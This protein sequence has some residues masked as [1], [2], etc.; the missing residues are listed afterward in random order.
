MKAR[1]VKGLD[2]EASLADNAE[3]IVLVRLDELHR[4]APAALDPSQE[5]ALHDMRIAA[6]RLR[7]VL[8]VTEPALGSAAKRGIGEARTLQEVLG[9]I[10]DCDVMLATVRA[11]AKRLRAEDAAAVRSALAPTAV[12]VKPEQIAGAPNLANYRGLEALV[13][14][15]RVRRDVLFAAFSEQWAELDR[16]GFRKSLEQAVAERPDTVEHDSA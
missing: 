1:K 2:C 4:L 6:K 9:E 3:R 13:T 12:D 10:H 15:L 7:Y 16:E 14:Y 5:E 8:E 11:H